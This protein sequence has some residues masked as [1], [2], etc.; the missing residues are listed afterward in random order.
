MSRTNSNGI[1]PQLFEKFNLIDLLIL[2]VF[3]KQQE[4]PLAPYLCE[5]TA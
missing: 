2:L 1:I 4:K 3:Q 5:Y